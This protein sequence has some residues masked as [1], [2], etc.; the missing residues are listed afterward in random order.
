MK[1][2]TIYFVAIIFATAL[3]SCK[4]GG[5]KT[6]NN[7]G[8]QEVVDNDNT[9]EQETKTVPNEEGTFTD[10]RDGHVYK[11]IKIGNQI[12]FAENLAYKPSSGT[13]WTY[14]NDQSNVAKYGYLYNWET[15]KNVC[16]D[17]YHLPTDDEWKELEME[18]GMTK[19]EADEKYEWRGTNQGEQLKAETGWEK[20]GNGTNE[21]GF[22]ALP[23]GCHDTDGSFYGVGIFC[24]WWSASLDSNSNAWR[25]SLHCR[26]S[27]VTC[28][29]RDKSMG[30]SIRCIKN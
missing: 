8:E 7:A 16:P 6:T 24:D 14:D 28:G 3:F 25:R 10:S 13:Y 26:T 17:G 2:I 4:G 22:S 20:D 1:K 5:E 15:A 23:G 18:L 12:W 11:T 29:A 9:D 19:T 30:I 27:G 21:S